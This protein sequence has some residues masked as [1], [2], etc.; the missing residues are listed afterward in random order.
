[1]TARLAGRLLAPALFACLVPL[2]AA[3]QGAEAPPPRPEVRD[4]RI[5]GTRALT[6]EEVASA[7]VTDESRCA[8][9]IY[10]ITFCP[11][12][13]SPTFWDRYYLDREAMRL[14][15]LRIRAYYWQRGYREAQVD[16]AVAPLGDDAVRVVF[17]VTEGPPIVVH[18]V[19]VEGVQGVLEP[20]VVSGLVQVDSGE[21]LSLPALD[22]SVMTVRE[23]LWE[24]GY[25]DALVDT[26][27]AVDSRRRASAVL[28]RADPRWVARVGAIEVEGLVRLDSSTVRNSLAMG[29]G[30][31]FRRS[32]LERGQRALYESNLFRRATI[33][34]T[35]DSVKTIIVSVAEAELHAARLRGGF[36]TTNFG[37]FDASYT[38]HNW[39]GKARRL[40]LE[41]GIGNLGARSLND[42]AFFRDVSEN[43]VGETDP[44]FQPTWQ[45]SAR[46]T[47]PWFRSPR[48][49]L[50][51][52]LFGHRRSEPAVVIDRGYGAEATFTREVAPRLP[53]SLTY[54]FEITE[55]EAGEVYY[56]V[57]FGVCDRPTIS[58]LSGE[59]RLSPLALVANINRADNVIAPTRGWVGQAALEHASRFTLSDYDYNRI[60]VELAGYRPLGGAVL[61]GLV[62][63]G[64]VGAFGN[65]LDIDR[66]IL[67]GRI[68]HP[69][70]RFYAGGSRSVRGFEES[71]L[72]PR[73]LTID[74]GLL[75]ERGCTAPFSFCPILNAGEPIPVGGDSAVPPLEDSDFDPRPT[76][77]FTLLEA[78]MELRFPVWGPLTGA[79]FVDG[80]TLSAGDVRAFS[81]NF[82]AITPGFGVRY[83][84]P[85]GPIRVDIGF[86][87]TLFR[88]GYVE[89][90]PVITEAGTD[91]DTRLVRVNDRARDPAAAAFDVREYAPGR[92]DSFWTRLLNSSVLHLSIG[93]AY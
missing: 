86:G 12:V 16:T 70:T 59:Q 37:Q 1:M 50:S 31:V 25:A 33:Q 72:G 42:R 58:T 74:P 21:A 4:L 54:R 23:A 63:G 11:F 62:R 69:R 77:G 87:P 41:A 56:C 2:A 66:D 89:G 14:D 84:S 3:T 83:R 20:D 57:N 51:A 18:A 29:P 35:G 39:R 7:I 13:H 6:A 32:A 91:G 34:A 30:D 80:A 53:V 92:G 5:E 38:N 90:L 19:R 49:T 75:E 71:Q 64:W 9:F 44:F 55:V 45:A 15:V 40:E 68:L 60:S 47:Q 93:E 85:V 67:G 26:A 36:S 82:G 28:L 48:N 10:R 52:A 8:N 65:P 79:V 78:S 27:V 76:G 22:S 24:R 61:A 81:N 46:V 17:R 88:P 73:V 43:V